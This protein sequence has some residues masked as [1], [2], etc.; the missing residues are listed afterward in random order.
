MKLILDTNIWYLLPNN[1]NLI[2]ENDKDKV[3]ATF[4]NYFEL[5]KTR[6]VVSNS[7]NHRKIIIEMDKFKK[8]F[9]SPFVH[10]AKLHSFYHYNDLLALQDYLDFL[11]AFKSG[12]YIDPQK[13]NDFHLHIDSVNQDFADLA[14]LF[15]TEA[16]KIKERIKNN[17]KHLDSDSSNSTN[18]YIL[19]LIHR[20]TGRN[21]DKFEF[22]K[23][24]LFSKT[25][26]LFFKKLEVGNFSAT[27]NDIIDFFMLSYVQPGDLYFTKEKKWMNLIKEAGCENYLYKNCG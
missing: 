1:P 10:M 7:E 8:L 20:A 25:L 17:K 16:A 18:L 12:D 27:T 21:L 5:L 24:E 9:T 6:S 13:I 23:I 15:N 19:D 4:L 14:K 26:N 22:Q 3:Y 11:V 2:D